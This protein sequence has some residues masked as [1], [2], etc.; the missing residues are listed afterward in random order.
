MY[1]Q[2][3][4]ISTYHLFF[5]FELLQT[6]KN[7]SNSYKTNFTNHFCFARAITTNAICL[8]TSREL[9]NNSA[10]LPNP[11]ISLENIIKAGR[12]LIKPTNALRYRLGISYGQSSHQTDASE[13]FSRV[14]ASF[15]WRLKTGGFGVSR[16]H[17][18]L[19]EGKNKS[20][21]R[22]KRCFR[23]LRFID[24]TFILRLE[25]RPRKTTEGQRESSSVSFLI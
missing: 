23:H 17:L 20:G 9:S 24:D 8:Y 2:H 13:G 19:R 10:G 21:C 7:S 4:N 16:L 5:L 11:L 6:S 15:G 18:R 3:I 1:R 14:A 22:L 25:A 12:Q